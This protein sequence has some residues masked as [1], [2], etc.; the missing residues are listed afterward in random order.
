MLDIIVVVLNERIIMNIDLILWFFKQMH[1]Y[2]SIKRIG[3]KLIM[4]RKMFFEMTIFVLVFLAF[5]FAFG[6]SVQSIGF[7]NAELNSTLLR[8]VFYPSYFVIA[9]EYYKRDNFLNCKLNHIKFSI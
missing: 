7:H 8:H 5:I 4:I 2:T 1:T 9:G 3:P 6:V